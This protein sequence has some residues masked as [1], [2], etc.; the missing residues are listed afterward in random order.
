MVESNSVL[1][2]IDAFLC[3]LGEIKEIC[4]L[5]TLC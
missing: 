5:L 2:G 4:L 3:D 1:L